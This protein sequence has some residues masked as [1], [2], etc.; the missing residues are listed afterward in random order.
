M[1]KRSDLQQ[2]LKAGIGWTPINRLSV[3]IGYTCLTRSSD[4]STLDYNA[5][6]LL[7]SLSYHF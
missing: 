1:A 7:T 3:D 4:D 6:T 2:E 5:H